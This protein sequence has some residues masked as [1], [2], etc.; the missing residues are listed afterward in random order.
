MSTEPSDAEKE[1]VPLDDPEGSDGG[2]ASSGTVPR[3][4]VIPTFDL[5]QYAEESETRERMPT[6][7][8]ESALEDARLQSFPTNCPPPRRS[9]STLPG[10]LEPN[11]GDASVEIDLGEQD[12]AALESEE[13][14]AILRDRLSPLTRVPSLAQPLSAIGAPLEDAKTAY[15]LGFVDGLLPL[16]TIID[17]TGLP[18]LDTLLVLDRMVGHNFIVFD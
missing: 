4:T 5:L 14:I 2:G 7:T 17:V 11:L 8:D 12:L 16:E 6:L 3:P 1:L 10:P 15:V 13:Q 18:E 9:L